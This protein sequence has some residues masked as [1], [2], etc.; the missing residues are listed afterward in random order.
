VLLDQYKG[1]VALAVSNNA[2]E[3]PYEDLKRLLEMHTDFDV[4]Y[5]EHSVRLSIDEHMHYVVSMA[6]TEYVYLL[7]D[8]DYFEDGGLEYL[9]QILDDLSPDLILCSNSANKQGKAMDVISYDDV[10]VA[11]WDLRYKAPFGSVLVKKQL[12]DDQFFL[13]LY[14]SAHGYSCFWV[15]LFWEEFNGKDVLILNV[16]KPCVFRRSEKKSYNSFKVLYRQI[17][18]GNE[19][20]K[21]ML[22]PHIA[23]GIFHR[24]EMDYKKKLVSVKVLLPILVT[25]KLIHFKETSPEIW[26]RYKVRITLLSYV[27]PLYLLIKKLYK[28]FYKPGS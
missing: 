25:T 22:P 11:Y 15:K 8:D 9:L 16:N 28:H 10:S 27:V 6:D 19:T 7:G 4:Q 24:H 1:R 14:G 12:L 5:Y 21:K 3:E 17:L 26:D 23:N 13:G 18:D 2:S 20:R